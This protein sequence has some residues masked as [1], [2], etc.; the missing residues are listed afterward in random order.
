MRGSGDEREAAAGASSVGHDTLPHTFSTCYRSEVSLDKGLARLPSV[1]ALIS[2]ALEEDLGRGD[3][4]TESV[5]DDETTATGRLVAREP[6]VL[7]GVDVAVAVFHR[8]DATVTCA[9]LASDGEAVEQNAVVLEVTGAAHAILRAER[10]ALNFVQR[11]S[12]VA[13]GAKR[14]ADAVRGTRA[15]VVDTRKTTP[16]Y[17]VLEKSAVRAGGCANH[18]FDLGSGILIKDNHIASCGS[19]AVAVA[20]ARERAPHSLR[21][22][23][24]VE[25]M[26]E[27]DQA[28]NAKA[29]IVLLDNMTVDQVHAACEKAHECG[30]LVEVS[31]GITLETVGAYARAGA[32]IISSGALT[33]SARAVD[34]A[35]EF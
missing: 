31:G 6:L 28:L 25:S 15:R 3:V 11:L 9:T 33:H 29:D 7:C 5:I 27:L 26:D 8:V 12:G 1:R 20:R 35:L 10:T 34:L 23:V 13:T 32:D 30:V 22:E 18:R 14:F 16:G 2:L 24:E 21:V 17:R 19:V 4:T